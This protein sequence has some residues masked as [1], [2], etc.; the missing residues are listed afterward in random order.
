[1]G[2][3]E[4]E[5]FDPMNI[6]QELRHDDNWI[7]ARKLFLDGDCPKLLDFDYFS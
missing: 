7:V 6:L 2:H 3:E 4:I 1:V 5:P